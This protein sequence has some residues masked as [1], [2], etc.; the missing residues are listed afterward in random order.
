MTLLAVP[1]RVRSA[2]QALKDIVKAAESGADMVELRVDT[3]TESPDQLI[4]LVGQSAVPCIVT[5]RDKREGGEYT[6]GAAGLIAL[7]DPLVRAANRPAYVDIELASYTGS[8]ELRQWAASVMANDDKPGDGP[9]LILSVHDFDRR[10]HDLLRKLEAMAGDSLCRV[11]K[12]AWQARSL[13]DNIESFEVI[14]HQYKPTIALCMGEFGLPSRVL[15][16]KFGA[17]LT[18]AALDEPLATAPGQPTLADLKNVY[19]WDRLDRQTRVYGVIGY[20]VG[21]SM[22]P[23]IHNAGFDAAGYNG[24]YLPM[25]IPPEYEHFKATV[26]QWLET[27][28]LHFRGASVTIPHKQNLLRFVKEQNGFVE[29]LADQI[30]AANTLALL[31]QGDGDHLF[32]YNT[33]YAAALDAVCDGLAIDRHEL[34]GRKVAVIGAGGAGRAIVTGFA[35][36]GADV[37]LYNRTLEKAEA[38]AAGFNGKTAWGDK[39]GRVR[40]AAMDKLRQSKCEIYINCTPIGMSPNTIDTPMPSEIGSRNFN[41][42]VVVFDTIYNPVE[43]RLIREAKEAGCTAITGDEMFIR[44][45]AAQFELWTNQA[46]PREV[47]RKILHEKLHSAP[48]G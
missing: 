1:I 44:Q 4:E 30:G 21:H 2:D 36:Y 24:V 29:P 3:F 5:C 46:A 40:A 9:G 11:I 7:L 23:A 12:T 15:A 18:F 47:F 45:A 14:S 35:H 33:D 16:K 6:G 38:I 32:A 28:P 10:P 26:G 20:P 39:P 8:D 48:R 41:P 17:L 27:A 19:R 31:D 37:T 22:S 42:D 34:A 13:R 43:T 25:P